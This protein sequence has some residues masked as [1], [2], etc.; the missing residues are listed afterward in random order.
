MNNGINGRAVRLAGLK[1]L[2]K[3]FC[4]Y[5]CRNQLNPTRFEKVINNFTS[6]YNFVI[7]DSISQKWV[8]CKNVKNHCER[9]MV[10]RSIVELMEIRDSFKKI[11][12]AIVYLSRIKWKNTTN[13]L[14]FWNSFAIL[15][16]LK[17][18]HTATARS[19]IVVIKTITKTIR[20]WLIS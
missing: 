17:S 14:I 12:A 6:R 9:V 20:L 13:R 18:V 7:W 2:E 16:S 15:P 19:L 10:Y 3:D 11:T 4:F 8:I 5:L 1:T